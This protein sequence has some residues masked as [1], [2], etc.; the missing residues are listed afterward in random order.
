[1]TISCQACTEDE[2]HVATWALQLQ[3]WYF[4]NSA[5]LCFILPYLNLYY[6]ELGFSPEQIGL[7]CALRPWVSAPAGMLC[8]GTG[9]PNL[10][11]IVSSSVQPDSHG[12]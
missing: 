3:A 1:M 7:I 2:K 8:L 4:L 9:W 6:S 10:H 12:L 5:S 11:E